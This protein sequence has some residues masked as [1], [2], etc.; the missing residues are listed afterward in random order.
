MQKIAILGGGIGSLAAAA[1]LTNDPDWQKNYE[2]TI[3][4][5]GWRLGGKGASGRNQKIHDRIQE[6]GIHLWM[7]FYENAFNLIRQIYAEAHTKVLMPNSPFT[8][9]RKAFTPM[10]LH[11]DDGAGR[12]GLEDVANQLAA[13]Q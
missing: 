10:N 11:A 4:Q 6:H 12:Q 2:I 13:E 5:M 3:Y 9:A 8:E 7:G 1:E